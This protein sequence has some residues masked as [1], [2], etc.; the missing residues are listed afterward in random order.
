[1]VQKIDW[2]DRYLDPGV[3]T[4]AII[5]LLLIILAGGIYLTIVKGVRRSL[6]LFLIFLICAGL[7]AL[8]YLPIRV[9]TS[10]NF[11]SEKLPALMIAEADGLPLLPENEIDTDNLSKLG[12]ILAQAKYRRF[13]Y[14][15][16]SSGAAYQKIR[17]YVKVRDAWSTVEDGD[18]TLVAYD[19]IIYVGYSD[20]DE[21]YDVRD[22]KG[23]LTA[24]YGDGSAAKV[25]ILDAADVLERMWKESLMEVQDS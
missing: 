18:N 9:D 16:A 12:S 15:E 6:W 4:V 24:Y 20:G 5:I 1:M 10:T 23:E 3:L 17:L 21:A 19:L 13:I 11:A 14:P 8:R 25:Q 2:L 7:F 22:V